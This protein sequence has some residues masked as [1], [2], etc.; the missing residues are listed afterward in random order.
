MDIPCSPRDFPFFIAATRCSPALASTIGPGNSRSSSSLGSLRSP[1]SGIVQSRRPS[2]MVHSSVT[3]RVGSRLISCTS[4]SS[5]V[6]G[7]SRSSFIPI[8][9]MF[10][11]SVRAL[12]D[13][14]PPWHTLCSSRSCP[15]PRL[16]SLGV[17]RCWPSVASV[18]GSCYCLGSPRPTNCNVMGLPMVTFVRYVTA[19]WRRRSTCSPNAH[20]RSRCG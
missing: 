4:S 18:C 7:F 13:I 6:D 1:Y 17:S 3:F 15:S 11:A 2:A 20:S 12:G 9:A 10:S 8:S 5:Y 14:R 16:V 19:T